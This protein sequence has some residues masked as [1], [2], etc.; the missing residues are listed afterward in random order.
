MFCSQ[1][2]EHTHTAGSSSASVKIDADK[3]TKSD[4]A[5]PP[6]TSGKGKTWCL[7]SMNRQETSPPSLSERPLFFLPTASM[8]FDVS[9]Y[10]TEF[11]KL[12]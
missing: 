9:L 3:A 7:Q 5:S 8:L 11:M 10:P 12:Q 6:N 1:S 4:P 2:S